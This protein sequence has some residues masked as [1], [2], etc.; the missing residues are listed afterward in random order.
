MPPTEPLESSAYEE[1]HTLART[2]VAA[3]EDFLADDVA[4]RL[5]GQRFVT[6]YASVK[7]LEYTEFMRV[8]SPWER[9]HLL[10]HV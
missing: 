10:L 5:F 2:F 1:K 3:H 8:I 4:V 9:Q 6:G 7:E